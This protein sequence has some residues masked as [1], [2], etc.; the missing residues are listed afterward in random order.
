M[1]LALVIAAILASTAAG[2][3]AE[4]RLGARAERIADRLLTAALFTVLPLVV[5]FNVVGL[6]LTGDVV[7]GLALAWVALLT[8]GGIAFLAGRRRWPRPTTGAVVVAVLAANT[9]YLGYPLTAVFLGADRLPE[10]VAYDVV[11]A[12]PMLVLVCFAVGAALG[13]EAGTGARERVRAFALRNPLLPAFALAL[14]SPEQLAPD[15]LVDLSQRL[16]FALLPVGFFAVG[17]HLAATSPG[18]FGISRPSP[19]LAV[20]VLARLLLAPALLLALALPLIELPAVYVLLAAMPA[21]L[22]TLIVA[23]AFGLDRRLAAGAIAWSTAIVLV[24]AVL[25]ALTGLA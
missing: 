21:G 13:E 19:E 10:A 4:L 6:E 20:A 8:A 22:N 23:G 2:A 7:G 24:A 3:A 25:A 9:G 18:S 5:Y 12:V 16:V 15:V 1:G 14:V 11:V 17:V